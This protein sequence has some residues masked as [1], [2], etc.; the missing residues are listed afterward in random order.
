MSYHNRGPSDG[1]R[2]QVCFLIT[3]GLDRSSQMPIFLCW[4]EQCV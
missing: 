1:D 2:G 3:H 4:Q